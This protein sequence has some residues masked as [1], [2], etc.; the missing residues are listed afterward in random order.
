MKTQAQNLNNWHDDNRD[1]LSASLARVRQALEQHASVGSASG[2]H[3][4]SGVSTPREISGKMEIQ[5]A[6]DT[7]CS[8]FG[9]S[10]FER[11]VLLMCAG[12]ELEGSFGALCASAHGD[13]RKAYP[14]FALALAAL[15]EAHW[16]ALAPNAPLRHWRLIELENGEGL[17]QSQL[18]IDERVLHYLAGVVHM[19][20]RLAGLVEPLTSAEHLAPSHQRIADELARAWA[21]T[22]TP[23]MPVIQLAGDGQQDKRAIAATGC[24][25]LGL[26]LYELSMAM[27][28]VNPGELETLIRLWQREAALSASAL[29]LDGSQIEAADAARINAL[30]RVMDNIGGPA[31]FINTGR[32]IQARVPV[33]TFQVNKPAAHEQLMVWQ[34]A[35]GVARTQRLNGRMEELA[36]QFNLS[37]S[38]IRKAAAEALSGD[39]GDIEECGR[40]LRR[41]CIFQAR[42]RL[43]N[44]AQRLETAFTWDDLA[45][46][47]PLRMMLREIAIHVRQRAK[48]Y[49]EWG[50]GSK[51]I[52]GQG[53][54]VLFSGA[55]GTGKTMAA[56]VLANDLDLDLYHIDLSQ[57][58]SKYI[59]ETEKNLKTVFDAA[60]EGGS[61]LLFDEADALFGKR[62]EIRDSHD[63][64]A[65]IEVSYL[66]QRMEAYRGLTILTTNMKDALDT[67]FLRRI[68]FVAQFPFPDL[69]QRAEIWRKV[70]PAGTPTEGLDEKKLA[71][72]NVAGGN[73]RNIA[74]NA[75]FMAADEGGPVRM[76]HL[77]RASR[78]EYAKLER[79]LMEAEIGGWL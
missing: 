19:D 35:V 55:S 52:R 79:P 70:F 50:F 41:S 1:Y 65:N 64:Y 10:C 54:S 29:L 58:V 62:S 31:I 68:R 2:R 48:V 46:P 51:G 12:M 16:N 61:I 30:I 26:N 17:T 7:L 59:G 39:S 74:L 32:N 63:R 5:P 44:L 15:P 33:I 71:R 38:S 22:D 57:M 3:D 66:L 69:S 49:V 21:R 75:A 25:A 27:A 6:L 18:R 28:P 47:E 45:L 76:E 8:L 24:R 78:Q 37:A 11:D 43:E 34:E 56:E 13:V 53:I 72:L 14:T 23:V 9:L 60:E 36:S 73:I 67:A 20:E 42:P 40:K 77:L 4:E